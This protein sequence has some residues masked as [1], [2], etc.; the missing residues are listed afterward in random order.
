MSGWFY[1]FVLQILVSGG[2]LKWKGVLIRWDNSLTSSDKWTDT[3]ADT[4]D[5]V[6]VSLETP[7]SSFDNTS[8][9]DTS[10]N[11]CTDNT[12]QSYGLQ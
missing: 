5:T 1:G 6:L 10:H 11:H 3:G 7:L 8:D 4:T 12:H 9:N 2:E